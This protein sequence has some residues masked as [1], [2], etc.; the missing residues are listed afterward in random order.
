M[1]LLFSDRD[2]LAARIYDRAPSLIYH[3]QL[4]HKLLRAAV[5]N[6]PADRPLRILEVGAGTGSL[7]QLLLPDL[8]PDRAHYVYTDITPAFFAGARERFKNFDFVDYRTLDLD[9]DPAEQGFVDGTFDIVIASNVLH[10]T[11]DLTAT[12]QRISGLLAD[13]GQLL[14]VEVTNVQLLLLVYGLLDSFWNAGDPQLRPDGPTL[15][16]GAWTRLLE[17]C[18]FRDVVHVGDSEKPA[19]LDWTTILASRS[20]RAPARTPKG[21]T[22][23]DDSARGTTWLLAGLGQGGKAI[24]LEHALAARVQEWGGVVTHINDPVE[25][26]SWD[27][28]LAGQQ[29]RVHLVILIEDHEE[30]QAPAHVT[31]QAVRYCA[32]L[33]AAARALA[34]TPDGQPSL[35][36]VTH[37]ADPSVELPPRSGASAAVWGAARS[38]LNE[39]P[40]LRL[41]RVALSWPDD[42]MHGTIDA[43]DA[44]LTEVAAESEEDE[45]LLTS[46]GRFVART[47]P[48]QRRR[49]IADGAE[50]PYQL[51]VSDPGARYQL[52]WKPAFHLEPG[53]GEVVVAVRAVGLNYRDVMVLQDQLPVSARSGSSQT[54]SMTGMECAGTVVATGAGVTSPVVGERVMAL[55]HC[56]PGSQGISRAAHTMPIPPDMTFAAAATLP[57]A[58][59]T[60]HHSLAH[61]A[62]LAPGETVLV[63]AGAGGVGMAALQYAQHV[64][65]TVIATAGT[66]AKRDMLRLLG[67]EHVLDSRSLR[68][69]DQVMDITGGQGVDVVLN[70][71]AGEG[72]GRSLE[73]LKRSG[74]FVELGKRDILQDSPVRMAAFTGNVSFFSVDVFSLVTEQMPLAEVHLRDMSRHIRDGVYRPL[75]FWT[76]P[77]DRI[78]E[79]YAYLQSSRHIGK[80]VV[81]YDEPV[82]VRSTTV[83]ARLRPDATYLIT[84][85]LSGLGAVT[86]RHLAER[87]ARHLALVSRRGGRAPEAAELLADLREHGVQTTA[88]AVDA[89]DEAAMK[90]VIDSIQASGHPLS[91]IIHGA[92]VLH[93]APLSELSDDDVR[94]VLAPKV[95]GAWILDKLTCNLNLDFFICYSSATTMLGNV[96]QSAYAASNAALDA[97]IRRRHRTGLPGLSIQWGAIA[98]A[99]YVERN[100]LLE[101]MHAVGLIPFPASQAMAE[102]S[103]LT[104]DPDAEM[105]V[106]ALP[107]W[108]RLVGHL[109]RLAAPR[110]ADL[111]PARNDVPTGQDLRDAINNADEREVLSLVEDA[112]C[113]L[114]ALVMQADPDRVA[115]DSR[116]DLMGVDSLMATEFATRIRDTL[117]YA[118]PTM[119]VTAAASLS[120]LA[121][122]V[123]RG[124]RHPSVEHRHPSTSRLEGHHTPEEHGTVN[125]TLDTK[126][127]PVD[128]TVLHRVG[129][130]CQ[131]QP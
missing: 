11:H 100:Q 50:R 106:V 31:E 130:H 112:L 91:G 101:R 58:F 6:W 25:Q 1:E 84:G 18:G 43:A 120:T 77:A 89:T 116:L 37:T 122:R 54:A 86:A 125:D 9:A 46:R 118:V 85:G 83:P 73:L 94:A 2:A 12:M 69:A 87:G 57:V 93:D 72:L 33:R 96:R 52:D 21:T 124:L 113:T 109:P 80:V 92:M 29:G 3:S 26:T 123:V 107:D 99:G 15:T 19:S 53:P 117:G 35:W 74:R 22:V 44:F 20:E 56:H 63:H 49:E 127:A 55:A 71:L 65:A 67:V 90:H 68:F 78:S 98:D 131:E 70:S 103:D 114:L 40:D 17:E 76:F 108:T 27:T 126:S 24:A 95:T 79:A 111:I 82:A 61:L 97:L 62:R 88:Y 7:T 13:H 23:T 64:G 110:I 102:L 38:V 119:E 39:Q 128:A 41:Q 60:V 121:E 10:A 28:A 81:T 105:V 42:S 16:R 47:R 75:P 51:A 36:I 48:A 5:A 8:P 30:R 66:P 104:G 129:Q 115:R 45:V 14:A 59:L 32:V 4:A 34:A